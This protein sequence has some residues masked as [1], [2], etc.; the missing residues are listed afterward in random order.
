MIDFL[1]TQG[2]S[3]AAGLDHLVLL[4]L[5]IVGSWFLLA[6][7]IL[8]GFTLKFRAKPGLRGQYITGKEKH[9]KRWVTYPHLAVLVFDVAIVIASFNVWYEIKMDLPT[10][11]SVIRVIGQQW[12]WTF[13]HPGPD[14]EL[15]TE[16]DIFT[17]D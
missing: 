8:F 15:D 11:D 7:G 13:Q 2:S 10:A 5:I 1:I 9:Q 6:L 4:I 3:Y 16:D 14:N 12:A 17:V